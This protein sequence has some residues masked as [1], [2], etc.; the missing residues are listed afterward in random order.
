MAFWA[1]LGFATHGLRRRA[2]FAGGVLCYGTRLIWNKVSKICA[3][4][5]LCMVI[6]KRDF[7]LRKGKPKKVAW[8]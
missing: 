7:K 1:A 2:G 6:A 4:G 8:H 3:R 5:R